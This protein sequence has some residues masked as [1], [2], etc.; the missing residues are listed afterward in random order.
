MKKDQSHT[1]RIIILLSA[2]FIIS[3]IKIVGQQIQR[4]QADSLLYRLNKTK[5][6]VEKINILDSLAQFHI[7]K[8]GE[9]TIDLDSAV[10]CLHKAQQLNESAKSTS[11]AGR[12]LLTESYLLREKSHKDSAILKLQEAIKIFE[13]GNDRFYLGKSLYELSGYY[14]W[15]VDADFKKKV[16]L[17]E[18]SVA[19]FEGSNG[20]LEKA[21]A[22]TMLGDLYNL[23][24]DLDK[25]IIVL[26]R[27]LAVYDSI[28]YKAM[29]GIYI[30]IGNVYTRKD[31]FKQALSYKLLALK[32]AE[33]CKDTTMQLCRIESELGTMYS[34]SAQYDL[35]LKYYHNALKTAIKYDDQYAVAMTVWNISR[36]NTLSNR[37][38][39]TFDLLLSL[40]HSFFHPSGTMEKAY[41]FMS[42]MEAY[43]SNKQFD[44]AGRYCDSLLRFVDKEDVP[45]AIRNVIYRQVADYYISQKQYSKARYFLTINKP[46]TAKMPGIRARA[47][48]ERLAYKLDSAEG[49]YRAA[50]DHL[51]SYKKKS[52]SLFD[53]TKS[54]QFQQMEV[55]YEIAEKEDSLKSKDKLITLLTQRSN[56]QQTN[57]KQ[58][59]L[60]RNITIGGIVFS[61]IA[62]GL[63]YDQFRKNQKSNKIILQINQQLKDMLIEKEWW[64]KEVH[65]RV[66]NNLHTIICLLESQA[67][68]LE[69]DAL[70]A[71]EKS[72]HRIYAM[73]LI[74]QKLYQNEDIR[75]IDMGIYLEEFIGYLRDSFDAQKIDFMI[76]VEP[77]QLNLQQAIPVALIINEGVTNSIKYAFENENEP[78]ICISMNETD[79]MVILTVMDNGKGFEIKAED[80][81]KSLGLQLIKGLSKELKGTVSIESKEGTELRVIFKKAA[82][83]DYM[84]FTEAKS[85][86]DEI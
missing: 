5:S 45:S 22:L 11:L 6:R 72:Q 62:I 47:S 60:I 43:Y 78:K 42:S 49:N 81:Q 55:E 64:L 1:L 76:N 61:L 41:F 26:K 23:G 54:R 35:A 7:F 30:T 21:D 86:S 29:Q 74:H 20:L 33:A 38:H 12:L 51:V 79:G 84:A 44:K 18:K 15:R 14:D 85:L 9:N 80:E 40:P 19:A 59:N 70:K 53:E 2:A 67:M 75:S 77:L 28:H 16:S 71:I 4:T 82:L 68:Y 36:I 46:L 3:S 39:N 65:H 25:A 24:G 69:K 83:A 52:D 66:K 32:A 17:V 10:T 50:F 8:P 73:S 27:A 48:D 58:A 63:L 57:L 56:L 13:S 34:L 31:D 37:Q